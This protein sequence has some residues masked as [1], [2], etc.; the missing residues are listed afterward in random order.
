MVARLR[1]GKFEAY[2]GVGGMPML[3]VLAMIG[4]P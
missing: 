3:G 2:D 1:D 4:W